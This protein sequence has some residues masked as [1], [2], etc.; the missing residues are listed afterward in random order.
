MTMQ[1][2]AVKYKDN[3]H[4]VNHP[5]IDYMEIEGI[6][7][8]DSMFIVYPPDSSAEG[9]EYIYNLNPVDG[10]VKIVFDYNEDISEECSPEVCGT[11]KADDN[12]VLKITEMNNWHFKGFMFK[13]EYSWKEFLDLN[14]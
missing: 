5:N 2:V 13:D 4:F 12:R 1:K 6:K 9:P 11:Y 7:L 14:K 10:S 8:R 3:N